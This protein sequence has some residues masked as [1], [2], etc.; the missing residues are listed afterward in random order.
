MDAALRQ[1]LRGLREGSSLARLLADHE[2]K[3]NLKALP[4]LSRKKILAWADAHFRRT[5]KWPNVNSGPIADAPR[6]KW[7]AVDDAL[8]QGHRGLSGGSSLLLLLAK[9]R[10]V[11]NPLDLPPLSK[12]QILGWADHHFQ[13]TGAWPKYYSGAIADA[14][15]ETWAAVDSALRLGKRGLL[16]GSSLAKLLVARGIVRGRKTRA[17]HAGVSCEAMK[18]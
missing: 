13:L 17:Q 8:R 2:K 7:N 5:G 1:G 9:K 3:R 14:P 18:I 6:E 11:R 4:P 10:G 12:E 16:G 15:G